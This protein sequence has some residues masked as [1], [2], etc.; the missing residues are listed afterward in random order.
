MLGTLLCLLWNL[1]PSFA[2][3]FK[4]NGLSNK[5]GSSSTDTKLS[6]QT[7]QLNI[8]TINELLLLVQFVL[9]SIF[10]QALI[11]IMIGKMINDDSEL[12]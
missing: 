9:A 2:A 8:L 3:L 10:G 5:L 6:P 1:L 7:N 12:D 11:Y 4:A